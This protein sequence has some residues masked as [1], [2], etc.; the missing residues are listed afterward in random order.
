MKYR[1]ALIALALL[2]HA[3][4]ANAVQVRIEYEGVVS[5][6]ST[7]VIPSEVDLEIGTSVSGYFIY[8]TDIEP[9]SIDLSPYTFEPE[10]SSWYGVVVQYGARIGENV[11]RGPRSPFL[12][13]HLILL[14]DW[15]GFNNEVKDSFLLSA[16]TGLGAPYPNWGVESVMLQALDTT[17]MPMLPDLLSN[18]DIPTHFPPFAEVDWRGTFTLERGYQHVFGLYTPTSVTATLVVPE[19]AEWLMMIAGLGVTGLI[20]R[21]RS[22]AGCQTP[23]ENRE[24]AQ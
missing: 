7:S 17:P 24:A 23:D 8:E 6:I 15:R 14:N 16:D 22:S 20:L 1:A 4:A 18:L 5:D 12:S 13:S 9:Y 11:T 3:A 19:P 21:K 2:T 10:R